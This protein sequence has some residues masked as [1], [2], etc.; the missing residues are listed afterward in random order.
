MKEQVSI[1][2]IGGK[3]ID[4]EQELTSFLQD[5]A[6]VKGPKMLVHGGGKVATHM[7]E[8]MGVATQMI[9]GR[10]VTTGEMLDVVLMVYGGLVNKKVV[11]RLQSLGC[12][13]TGL[14]GADMNSIIAEKRPAQ[15][16]DYGFVGD[17][18]QINHSVFTN[19]LQQNI[20][21]VLAPLTHD[22][23]GQLLNTNAD[24]IAAATA[25]ALA[26]YFSAGLYFC[27]EKAGVL[28][29][30]EDEASLLERLDERTYQNLKAEGIIADGM[31][32]KLDNA[33]HT[34]QQGV[35]HVCIMHHSQV[36]NIDKQNFKAT[37]LCL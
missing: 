24:T 35:S 11:A 17:I 21:P 14:T 6:A 12:N 34:L 33:F 9:E 29:D 4:H 7:A 2:K 36:K 27:F 19:L 37:T 25:V 15:P 28:T 31:V 23:Q 1:F 26:A 30:I 3:V 8:R 10:R 18:R 5:F 20:T 22:R 32:P 16:V 13:A